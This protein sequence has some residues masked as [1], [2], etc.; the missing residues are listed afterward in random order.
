MT[1]I[2]VVVAVVQQTPLYIWLSGIY[3]AQM[4]SYMMKPVS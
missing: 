2:V 3:P 4:H 1:G